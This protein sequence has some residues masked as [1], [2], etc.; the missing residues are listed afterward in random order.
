MGRFQDCL[1]EIEGTPDRR[2]AAAQAASAPG[3]SPAPTRQD[4]NQRKRTVERGTGNSPPCASAN[5]IGDPSSLRLRAAAAGRLRIRRLVPACC[6][7]V[8]V[9]A[10]AEPAPTN[11]GMHR[12]GSHRGP[13]PCILEPSI[14]PV[15]RRRQPATRPRCWKSAGPRQYCGDHSANNG[16][17]TKRSATARRLVAFSTGA[18]VRTSNPS[19][20]SI[21][22]KADGY[23]ADILH[24]TLSP[25]DE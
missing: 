10:T 5:S 17:L 25:D 21:R 9:A 13:M 1:I 11:G 19:A 8:A 12:P 15:V 4:K 23:L 16:S 18:I 3:A 24:C 7:A 6:S 20:S 22:P 14:T 2:G